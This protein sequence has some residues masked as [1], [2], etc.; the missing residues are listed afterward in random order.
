MWNANINISTDD[1]WTTT[2]TTHKKTTQLLIYENTWCSQWHPKIERIK[3]A[4]GKASEITIPL[5]TLSDNHILNVGLLYFNLCFMDFSTRVRLHS[6]QKTH[7][8]SQFSLLVIEC[9]RVAVEP[10]LPAKQSKALYF[11]MLESLLD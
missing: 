8:N 6:N 4:D 11:I 1:I 2:Q 7:L 3:N 10:V 5:D 9:H